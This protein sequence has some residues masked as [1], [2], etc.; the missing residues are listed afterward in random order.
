MAISTTVQ[1]TLQRYRE[2]IQAA[3]R[4]A[5]ARAT[6][7]TGAE[8]SRLLQDYYGQMRYH[9][10]WVDAQLRPTSVQTGKLLRPTLLL[11]SY[12]AA[13]AWGQ[14]PPED[15]PRRYLQRALPA[16]AAI[17]LTHNFTLI[18]DD[19]V[20]EDSER[21]HRPT[22]WKLWGVP[23]AINAG[24]GMFALSR[25]ALW[26]VLEAGVDPALAA[27]LAAILD[28]TCLTI[29]E[30]Q[31]LDMLFE[32]RMDVSVA[33]YIEM[34]RRKTAALMACAAEMGALLGTQD[35]ETVER[36]RHFGEA[37]GL[38][39]Q[40][41]DDVLGVWASLDELGKNPAG[42]IYRRKKSLPILHALAHAQA[43]DR[44]RLQVLYQ[45]SAP[46]SREQVDEI[47][48]IFARTETRPYCQAFLAEQ[49]RRAR[50]ALAAVP[51]S[52]TPL[53]RRARSDLEAFV[54]FI[55]AASQN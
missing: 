1:A 27:R 41:R 39:F 50:A 25:L 4:E 40:V 7:S 48:A 12:E 33:A 29:A 28:R 24:D 46:L 8:A 35:A 11:L 49:C 5:V 38:A 13:G 23:H 3:L 30:G 10:G 42:D 17:E 54:A 19:I 45:Q 37:I 36:L 31:Y 32:T 34:I 43:A 22:V 51:A 16:A 9:L 47:L 18:H 55:E 44:E 26:G 52:S 14:L 2:E 20:D 6:A 53:A 15:E 21:H